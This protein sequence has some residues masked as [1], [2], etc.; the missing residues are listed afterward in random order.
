[1]VYQY[2]QAAALVN[3]VLYARRMTERLTAQ[4]W[5]DSA[6]T[7]LARQGFA[8]LKAEVLARDLGI[9]RGSFYWHFSD[10]AAFHERVIAQWKLRATEEIIADIERH[11]VPE[12]RLDALLRHAFGHR[13]SLEMHMRAWA[14]E[15]ACAAQA[16]TDIDRRRR[17][18]LEKLLIQAGVAPAM[19][20][21]RGLILY[22]TYLG[23]ASSRGRLSG[24]KLQKMVTELKELV[25]G[26][27]PRHRS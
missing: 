17:D 18:Y 3:T 2:T 11:T 22:W 5:I 14:E 9:S 15:N 24:D 26:G 23:A 25:L 6:L 10:L 16:V 21:T 8:A 1:M 19:A 27:S 4:D 12:E 13:G 7:V 20:P